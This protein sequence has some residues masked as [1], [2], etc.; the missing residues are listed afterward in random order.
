MFQLQI[1]DTDVTN[2]SIAVSWCLDQ[3]MLKKL[4]DAGVV[5]PQVVICVAPADDYHCSQEYRKMV[6]LKELMTYIEFRKS[7]KNN[8][9]GFISLDKPRTIR[10]MYFEKAEGAYQTNLLNYDGDNYST[11]MLNSETPEDVEASKFQF[12]SRPVSVFVPSEAFAKE[13]TQFEKNWVNHFFRDK[14]V[15]QCQFRKRRLFA[16]LVQPW[17]IGFTWLV[18]LFGV[19]AALLTAQKGLTLKHLLSPLSYGVDETYSD[20]FTEG[21]WLVPHLAEDDKHSSDL[22]SAWYCVRKFGLL[23]F[24]PLLLLV[25]GFLAYRHCW[26]FLAAFSTVALAIICV[27][28]TACII[29]RNSTTIR[30]QIDSLMNVLSGK[31]KKELA[32]LWYLDQDESAFITCSKE[33]KPLRYR[34]IPVGRKTIRLRFQNLKSKVCRPFSL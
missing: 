13:P 12:L 30:N 17:M 8:I 15:D 5:D 9:W 27:F 28:L 21:C 29:T 1:A 4:A 34:D 32:P 18:K 22:P 6:P 33:K 25:F 3:E 16:Y 2:G 11:M 31:Q 7:G 19:V 26:A 14:V 23:I 24:T 10:S 20:L